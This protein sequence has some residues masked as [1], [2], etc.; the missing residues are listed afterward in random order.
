MTHSY[1]AALVSEIKFLLQQGSND[2][3]E[4]HAAGINS[5]WNKMKRKDRFGKS[6]NRHR[7]LLAAEQFPSARKALRCFV[8]GTG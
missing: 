1:S 3:H 4:N 5:Y 6:S 2:V 8:S 7:E